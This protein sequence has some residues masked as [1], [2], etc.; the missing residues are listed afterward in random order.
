M[1]LP[2]GDP[3]PITE[4]LPPPSPSTAPARQGVP[5]SNPGGVSP[6]RGEFAAPLKSMVG[7]ESPQSGAAEGWNHRRPPP[8]RSRGTKTHLA[9]PLFLFL[10]SLTCPLPTPSAPAPPPLFSCVSSTFLPPIYRPNPVPSERKQCLFDGVLIC[11]IT[12]DHE[13]CLTH[14]TIPTPHYSHSL[15]SSPQS[16][17][18]LII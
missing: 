8:H 15:P 1:P 12:S 17:F 5:P 9:P 11:P 4:H 10:L 3:P 6:R 14:N 13:M 18:T 2:G 7:A 16:L